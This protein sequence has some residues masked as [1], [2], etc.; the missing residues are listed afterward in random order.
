MLA[1]LLSPSSGTNLTIPT[2]P[3][4]VTKAVTQK[5]AGQARF[6]TIHPAIGG[7]AISVP[8]ASPIQIPTAFPRSRSSKTTPIWAR[9]LGNS[10]AI[11]NPCTAL[12]PSSSPTV[13][14]SAAAIVPARYNQ[15]PS[16][17]VRRR[18]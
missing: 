13:G 12:A 17:M 9:A 15:Y 10:S 16:S 11:P 18:P 3:T 4:T 6:S 2:A 7:P 8:D 5:M 1:C 14:V